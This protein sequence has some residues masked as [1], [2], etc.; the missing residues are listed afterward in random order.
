M[1]EKPV[2]SVIDG[3]REAEAF[4]ARHGVP[5]HTVEVFYR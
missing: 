2:A 3:E 4:A 5:W 1:I